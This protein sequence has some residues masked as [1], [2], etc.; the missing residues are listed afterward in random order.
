MSIWTVETQDFAPFDDPRHPSGVTDGRFQEGAALRPTLALSNENAVF[1]GPG[2]DLSPHRIAMTTIAIAIE[3]PFLLAI[4]PQ[5]SFQRQS[6]AII[7]AGVRHQLCADGAMAF[8]YTGRIDGAVAARARLDLLVARAKQIGDRGLANVDVLVAFGQ[9]LDELGRPPVNRPSQ[10][11]DTAAWGIAN[12]PL[13]LARACDAASLAGLAPQ[14]FRR[15]LKRETG[16]TFRQHRAR[17]R[18]GAVLRALGDGMSL[19]VAAH[20]AGF[21]S[22]AHLSAVFRDM[23]GI[24]PSTLLK[25][26]TRIVA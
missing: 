3:R 21:S 17:A 6:L 9:M 24:A 26:R 8:V 7:P 19:T 23:F 11:I 14:R 20:G 2:L 15:L 16:L 10:Q 25:N 5:E 18:V 22:S 13:D 1:V 12:Y 4:P